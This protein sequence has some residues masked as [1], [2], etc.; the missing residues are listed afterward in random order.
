VDGTANNAPVTV[1]V[2]STLGNLSWICSA[3]GGSSCPTNGTGALST[4]VTLAPN[5]TAT[6]HLFGAID[7]SALGTLTVNAAVTGPPGFGGAPFVASDVDNL[8]PMSSLRVSVQ[9]AGSGAKAGDWVTYTV[10]V[11]NGGPSTGKGIVAA[12]FNPAITSMTDYCLATTGS[13]C[14]GGPT[15]SLIAF[16]AG[17]TSVLSQT[18]TVVPGGRIFIQ[19]YGQIP[20]GAISG[21][22]VTVEVTT[23]SETGAG[24]GAKASSP[25]NRIFLPQ[26]Q[27]NYG[28]PSI[29]SAAK[30]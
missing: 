22:R 12:T 19:I 3:G 25:F 6:F 11:E 16:A 24:P 30:R 9:D 13:S 28:P 17:S 7:P 21:P 1:A 5:G 2:P 14:L 27:N 26:I 23:V 29:A 15:S 20:D 4:T 8:N 18:V 10:T